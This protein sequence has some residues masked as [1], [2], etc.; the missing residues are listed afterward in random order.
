L[1][2]GDVVAGTLACRTCGQEKAEAEFRTDRSSSTG[3][4][5]PCREC[6]NAR[7]RAER[8][9]AQSENLAAE[10]EKADTEPAEV[11]ALRRLVTDL[12]KQLSHAKAA[13]EIMVDAAR[14]IVEPLRVPRVVKPFERKRKYN[15]EAE[16]QVLHLS[17]MQIGKVT[18][19]YNI[20]RFS[21]EMDDL[22]ETCVELADIFR[23]D[24]PVDELLIAMNGDLVEGEDIFPGQPWVSQVGS[25][26]QAVYGSEILADDIARVA[27]HWPRIRIVGTRGNHGRSG[28]NWCEVSNWDLALVKMLELHLR[29][30]KNV[31]VEVCED[32]YA[33]TEVKGKRVMQTHGDRIRSGG[34]TPFTAVSKRTSN[35]RN[36]IPVEALSEEALAR[37]VAEVA[38]AI[39][40]GHSGKATRLLEAAVRKP[41]DVLLIGH[42]HNYAAFQWHGGWVLMNG[43]PESSNDYALSYMGQ[44]S[45]P[46]QSVFF[47]HPRRGVT[48]QTPVYLGRGLEKAA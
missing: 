32:W 10:A 25:F 26:K 43:S 29:N 35:W 9:A 5:Q 13:H 40:E 41:F 39:Q 17:D 4:K 1:R 18:P 36:S 22:F 15:H 42:F 30:V 12:R 6:D 24:H 28:K 7:K 23:S 47:V 16:A 27:H 45:N 3:R 2:E 21:V 48:Y 44:A 34:D 20:E 46:M 31:S 38:S 33:V 19:T 37:L 14:E 11:A 8:R